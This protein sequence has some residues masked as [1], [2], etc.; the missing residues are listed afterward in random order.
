M[1]RNGKARQVGAVNAGLDSVRSV[2]SRRSTIGQV[3]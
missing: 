1:S 3:R 2:E